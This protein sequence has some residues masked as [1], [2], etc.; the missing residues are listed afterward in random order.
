MFALDI[1]LTA[2]K[3]IPAVVAVVPEVKATIDAAISVLH[4]DSQDAAKAGYE[5]LIAD[6]DEGFAELD[7]LAAE[8]ATK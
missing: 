2:L 5:A 7:R 6:N 4:P 8:A 3:A 1:F